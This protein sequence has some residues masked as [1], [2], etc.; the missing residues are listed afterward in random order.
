[1]LQTGLL[2]LRE[3]DEEDEEVKPGKSKI[4]GHRSFLTELHK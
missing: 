1:M 2:L 3:K 4:V